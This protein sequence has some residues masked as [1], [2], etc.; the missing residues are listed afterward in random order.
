MNEV[1]QS[2]KFRTHCSIYVSA[3][4]DTHQRVLCVWPLCCWHKL[5]AAACCR[6]VSSTSTRGVAA[7]PAA[8]GNLQHVVIAQK[9]VPKEERAMFS[10]SSTNDQTKDNG[11]SPRDAAAAS[12]SFAAAVAKPVQTSSCAMDAAAT[13]ERDD[14]AQ[15]SNWRIFP[16]LE[17]FRSLPSYLEEQSRHRH[18]EA[19]R[20]FGVFSSSPCSFAIISHV[21]KRSAL[22][23]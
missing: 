18:K 1:M 22:L 5:A 15:L 3:I 21:R 16:F 17:S 19:A 2:Q 9:P 13:P 11:K 7:A 23:I 12:R 20:S 10:L 4:P 6:E 8:E 14:F